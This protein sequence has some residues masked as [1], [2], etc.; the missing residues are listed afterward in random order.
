MQPWQGTPTP[1]RLADGQGIR[2]VWAVRILHGRERRPRPGEAV[3]IRPRRGRAWQGYVRR[4]LR[5]EIDGSLVL[6]SS[7]P[8]PRSMR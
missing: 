4:T 1:Y 3:T 2:R 6:A 8:P 5:E 7:P